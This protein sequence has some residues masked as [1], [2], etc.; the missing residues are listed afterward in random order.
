MGRN[1]ETI[2]LTAVFI[3]VSLRRF[4]HPLSINKNRGMESLPK[5]KKEV[6]II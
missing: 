3:L 6:L 4:I 2:C 1:R 5:A